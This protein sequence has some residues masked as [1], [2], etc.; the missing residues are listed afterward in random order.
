MKEF[1]RHPN[2][3]HVGKFQFIHPLLDV[4]HNISEAN[5]NSLSGLETHRMIG[6]KWYKLINKVQ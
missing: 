4:L 5:K 3:D 6:Y 1:V 2:W